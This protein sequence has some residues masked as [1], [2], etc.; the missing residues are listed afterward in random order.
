MLTWS[1]CCAFL[2]VNILIG[3]N[4]LSFQKASRPESVSS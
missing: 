1:K 3:V 2:F 4:T